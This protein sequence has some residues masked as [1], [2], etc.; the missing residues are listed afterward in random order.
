MCYFFRVLLVLLAPL[1]LLVS[2]VLLYVLVPIN[3]ILT[4]YFRLILAE[5]LLL[6]PRVLLELRETEERLVRLET[7]A[8]KDTE[9]SPAWLV[10]PDLL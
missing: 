1:V 10:C 8:T 9:D 2:V 4:Q 3:V 6:P 5:L 7:E